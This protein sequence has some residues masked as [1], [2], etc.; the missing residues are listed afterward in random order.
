MA[1]PY[2]KVADLRV[3]DKTIEY[4]FEQ[5]D[6]ILDLKEKIASEEGLVNPSKLKLCLHCLE[7]DDKCKVK[8]FVDSKDLYILFPKYASIKCDG[9]ETF[10]F[11]KPSFGR[12]RWLKLMPGRTDGF[13]IPRN[14]KF[15]VMRN[16]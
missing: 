6:T 5:E 3:Q 7:L 1:R 10:I 14:G 11:W 12:Q 8:E 9:A 2:I 13:E 15:A 4:E 16:K